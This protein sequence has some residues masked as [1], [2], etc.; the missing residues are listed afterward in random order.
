MLLHALDD[1]SKSPPHA[2]PKC[3][4]HLKEPADGSSVSVWPWKIK[5]LKKTRFAFKKEKKKVSPS[6]KKENMYT[7]SLKKKKK[8][9][10]YFGF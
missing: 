8:S 2:P 10:L 3:G 4:R 5:L 6:T 9:D 1:Q 7:N